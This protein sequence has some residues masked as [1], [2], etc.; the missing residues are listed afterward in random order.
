LQK[1]AQDYLDFSQFAL[2]ESYRL[3]HGQPLLL[4]MLGASLIQYFNDQ[5]EN[6]ESRSNYVDY[7]DIQQA[8]D[9]LVKNRENKAFTDHWD[10]SNLETQ[11]VLS[12]FAT[13]SDE[14]NCPQLDIEMIEKY[15]RDYGFSLNRSKI[16]E[17]LT[18]LTA[19]EILQ[20][21]GL[22]YS[23]CVPLYRRW[24]KSRYSPQII[25]EKQ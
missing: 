13:V 24:I 25:K 5:I 20:R 15:L 10:G 11:S 21:G 12:V 16:N 8:V 19:E 7:N 1:N 17:I 22:S 9:N 6:G 23:F 4:Q 3:T 18:N 2:E 14:V